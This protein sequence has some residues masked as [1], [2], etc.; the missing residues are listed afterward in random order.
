MALA[1]HL[2]QSTLFALVVGCLTLLL[3]KNS[4]RVRCLLWLAASTKFLIPFAL[5]TLLGSQRCRGLPV[6]FMWPGFRV[7]CACRSRRGA[8]H[9]NQRGTCNRA[10]AGLSCCPLRQGD[11]HCPHGALGARCARCG[12]SLVAPLAGCAARAVRFD[13]NETGIRGS[14]EI[15]CLAIRAGSRGHP[16]PRA[17]PAKRLGKPPCVRGDGRRPGSRSLPRG[18]A[19]QPCG[20]A[21]HARGSALLVLSTRLVARYTSGRGARACL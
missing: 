11:F 5:L 7:R 6:Q 16:P 12:G 14:G 13:S 15:V 2:W 4:A 9:A 10:C 19:R 3:R 21:S 1:N 17:A 18:M 8:G 20:S